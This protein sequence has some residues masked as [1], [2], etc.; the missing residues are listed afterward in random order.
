MARKKK[1]TRKYQPC[2]EFRRNISASS[3]GHFDYVFGETETQYKSLGLTMHPSREDKI[4]H[5]PLTKNPNPN[6][7]RQS[8]LRLKPHGTNKKYLPD[9]GKQEEWHFAPEDMPVVRHTIKKYKKSTNRKPK[10]W[11]VK[12]AKHN[13]KR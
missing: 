6:D 11:Y 1:P 2:N 8:Y 7:E 10:D 3:Q 13:R 9:E 5:Y 4:P 12:K